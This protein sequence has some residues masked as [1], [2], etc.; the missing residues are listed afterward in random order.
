MERKYKI[1][2]EL[3]IQEKKN[4]KR[5]DFIFNQLFQERNISQ[6]TRK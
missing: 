4:S 6:K 3:K 5:E 2:N 1:Q